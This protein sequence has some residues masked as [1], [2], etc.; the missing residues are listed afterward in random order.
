MRTRVLVPILT[1]CFVL[2]ISLIAFSTGP[3]IRRTG[4]PIDGGQTCVVCHKT[5]TTANSD[6]R[7]SVRIDVA[8]YKPGTTQTI[9]VTINHPEQKRWGFQLTARL[10]SDSSQ[11][12][13]TFAVNS[14]VRVRCDSGHDAPCNGSVDSSN[15]QF[16][17]AGA[18]FTYTVDWTPREQCGRCD[19]LRR[20]QCR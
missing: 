12:A 10:A 8:A 11:Q 4:A 14:L 17:D 18:G 20:G 13:G 2:P 16:T 7:G 3:P 6:P 9:R 15:A 5:F 19:L 1:T